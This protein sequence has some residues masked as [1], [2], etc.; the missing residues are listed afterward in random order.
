MV[1][2]ST[3]TRPT[4][5]PASMA[6]LHKV[7][8][9]SMLR[10]RIAL[11][12]NSIAYPVAPAVPSRPMMCS[13]RSLA[14]KPAGSWPSTRT[15]M[16]CMGRMARHCV[17]STCSTSEVPTPN[18]RA[19]N[20]PCVLVCESPATTVMP[21]SVAPCSGPTTWMMPW[22]WL[23]RPC[24]VIPNS[25]QLMPS[26]RTWARDKGSSIASTEMRCAAVVGTLWSATAIVV[27]RRQG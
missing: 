15:R 11:P 4:R 16:R 24:K 6:I 9:P 18:A 23:P 19:A 17:A 7:M 10:S 13:T 2:S 26:W 20:A 22:V 1:L 27:S 12:S 21:G 5:A 8:R 14:D 25:W 3:A